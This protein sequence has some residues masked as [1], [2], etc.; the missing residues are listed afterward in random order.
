MPPV[1]LE[2]EFG[3]IVSKARFGTE[4]SAL[5]ISERTGISS[6]ELDQIE[7]YAYVPPH[8]KIRLLADVLGLHPDKLIDSA[9]KA[10]VP[11]NPQGKDTSGVRVKMLPVGAGLIANCYILGCTETKMGALIDPGAEAYRIITEVESS[12]LDFQYILLTHGHGDHVGALKAAKDHLKVPAL[13]HKK[14]LGPVSSRDIDD[15]I[16]EGDHVQIG[17]LAVSVKLTAGHTKGGVSFVTVGNSFTGDALFA[18]S[19]GGARG[20]WPGAY[21][22]QINSVK[23]KILS[24][25]DETNLF[26]GHGP[27]TTV[28]EEKAHNPFFL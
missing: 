23:D 3:D 13:I 15:T 9:H 17:N 21:H 20:G 2:D 26:C 7:G 5:Q 6:T 16:E 24:L 19:M 14:E 12:G 10:W 25:S 1:E 18:G 22:D 11:E 8:D 4:I 28:G 27:A